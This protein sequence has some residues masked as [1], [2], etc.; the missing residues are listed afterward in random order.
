[1]GDFGFTQDV[2]TADAVVSSGATAVVLEAPLADYVLPLQAG[3][4]VTGRVIARVTRGD[5]SSGSGSFSGSFP[6]QVDGSVSL[7]T[8]N[9]LQAPQDSG[10]VIGVGPGTLSA[11]LNSS[12]NLQIKFQAT[13]PAPHDY[14]DVHVHV[15][16][17]VQWHGRA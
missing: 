5:G 11:I 2:L 4:W 16:L 6:F 8:S 7:P 9:I 3:R 15:E 14:P 13:D 12:G 1:M 10:D 17:H